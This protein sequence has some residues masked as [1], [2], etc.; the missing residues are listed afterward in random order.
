ML[1][2]C[3]RLLELFGKQGDVAVELQGVLLALNA[4][5]ANTAPKRNRR[6]EARIEQEVVVDAYTSEERAM[7]WYYYLQERLRFP[8]SATCSKRRATS[9]F[10]IGESLSIT[11]LAPEDDCMSEI[12]VLTHWHGRAL[13]IPLAQLQPR[14]LDAATKEAI[15]DWHYWVGMGYQY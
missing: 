2:S 6:R 14:N 1:S 5:A 13:G 7:G 8:F 10:K 4:M 11:R 3:N 12:I 15:E 9:P